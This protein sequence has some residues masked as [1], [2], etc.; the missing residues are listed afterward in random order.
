MIRRFLP[1]QVGLELRHA[2]KLVVE[3]ALQG[4]RLA[5]TG[6]I[7][8]KP[9]TRVLFASR[10]FLPLGFKAIERVFKA[11][12]QTHRCLVQIDRKLTGRSRRVAQVI[13]LASNLVG[14]AARLA[15]HASSNPA[16]R[17]DQMLANTPR[18]FGKSDLRQ[19]QRARRCACRRQP[20]RPAS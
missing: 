4:E 10:L 9:R 15:W 7:A 13:R 3:F 6:F 20:D 5:E 12:D 17:A 8:S 19:Q 18:A 16:D 14:K 2:G 11:G 1:G